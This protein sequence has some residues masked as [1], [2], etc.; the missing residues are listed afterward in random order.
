MWS[1]TLLTHFGEA[2]S[3]Q[4]IFT[5]LLSEYIDMRPSPEIQ[6]PQNSAQDIASIMLKSK[7]Q[8]RVS[9][10]IFKCNLDAPFFVE[11]WNLILEEFQKK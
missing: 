5:K 11:F 8:E 2:T 3:I 1:S 10:K 7:C 4:H 9:H 6:R